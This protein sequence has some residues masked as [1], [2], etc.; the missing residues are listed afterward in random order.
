MRLTVCSN[1]ASAQLQSTLRVT[2]WLLGLRYLLLRRGS[3][4]AVRA[5]F[6][7]QPSTPSAGIRRCTRHWFSQFVCYAAD[8]QPVAIANTCGQLAELLQVPAVFLVDAATGKPL[9]LSGPVDSVPAP[10]PA[11]T[12]APS[13]AM[14]AL[15]AA[16]GGSS[17]QQNESAVTDMD[18]EAMRSAGQYTDNTVTLEVPEP[19]GNWSNVACAGLFTVLDVDNASSFQTGYR[20]GIMQ[21]C[22][23]GNEAGNRLFCG[24]H[25]KAAHIYLL[26]KNGDLLWH[27]NSLEELAPALGVE[28][29]KVQTNL[30]DL[31]AKLATDSAAA[32]APAAASAGI[33]G[34][35]HVAGGE[36]QAAPVPMPT[37]P[38]VLRMHLTPEQIAAAAQQLQNGGAQQ[39][40]EA[41]RLRQ[42]QQGWIDVQLQ[43]AAGVCCQ[44]PCMGLNLKL[45]V[46]NLQEL[47]A[48]R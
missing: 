38:P 15:Q 14:K 30:D 3:Y 25:R 39:D 34:G 44:S 43:V 4:T 45:G 2:W 18:F 47:A 20:Y 13:A 1:P 16:E 33:N 46:S 19:Q 29:V 5:W 40:P 8:T 9:N 37:V 7:G 36:P 21:N 24:K 22:R 31:G 41:A 28:A 35:S 48:H 26:A 42:L 17:Q 6:C 11:K 27:G 10:V 23:C 12:R 32:E